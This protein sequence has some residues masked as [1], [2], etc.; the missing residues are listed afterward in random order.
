MKNFDIVLKGKVCMDVGASRWIYRLYV[1][2]VQWKYIQ[3]MSGMDS[4]TKPR[5]D[6]RVVLWN[7]MNMRYM[8]EDDIDEKYRLSID[9]FLYSDKILS[10]ILNF[11]GGELLHWLNY[12]LAGRKS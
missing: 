2:M 1:K 9:V 4:W 10:S 12:S 11:E 7:A 8:T 3:L 6:E 5:N